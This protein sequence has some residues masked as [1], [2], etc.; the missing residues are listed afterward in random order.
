VFLLA[1]FYGQG[2]TIFMQADFPKQT[3]LVLG[4]ETSCDETAVALV[5]MDESLPDGPGAVLA[6]L[7][8]SQIE[9]HAL[10]GGVV[11][12]LA[13]RAHINKLDHMI[14]EAVREAGVSLQDLHAV[15]ATA[16]PGLI[17]G[18]IVGLV[19]GKALASSLNV[20]F[21]GINHLEGHALTVR[22]TH[23]ASFPYLLLLVSGGHTQILIVS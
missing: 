22:M 2:Y 20:P 23:G 19:S 1:E 9:D 13:A 16:G 10:Y 5:S 8:S 4:I 6:S 7:V 14:K 3:R 17:G 15:A 18:V 12:E 21:L 11:P